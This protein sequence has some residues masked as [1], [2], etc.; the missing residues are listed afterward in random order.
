MIETDTQDNKK[1]KQPS[2]PT[3]MIET[4]KHDPGHQ[5]GDIE[6]DRDRRPA[7]KVA[8]KTPAER[9]AE[10][11]FLTRWAKD[12]TRL[13]MQEKLRRG[14]EAKYRKEPGYD[15]GMTMGH[16]YESA[17]LDVIVSYR[18]CIQARVG[19]GLR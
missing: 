15:N 8:A 2:R 9:A 14:W 12:Q 19:Q 5:A 3:S 13:A 1:V 10:T 17:T 4:D 6:H 18:V 7:K 16:F 11:E